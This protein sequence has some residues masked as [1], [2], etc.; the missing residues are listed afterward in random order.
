MKLLVIGSCTGDKD[1]RDCPYTLTAEDF[2]DPRLLRRRESDLEQWMMPASTLYKG[3]QHRYMMRGIDALRQHYGASSCSVKIISAGYGLVGEQQRLA[4]YEVTFQGNRPRAVH[5]RADKLGIPK[6]IRKAV[7]GFD[8]VV[9]L[10]G[11]EYLW[12]INLPLPPNEGQRL[13]FLTSE[14][15]AKIDSRATVVPA[16]RSETRFGAGTVALKGR[17]FQLFAK[18]LCA[19][20]KMWPKL[21]ADKTPTT[22]LNLIE[23]GQKGV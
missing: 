9:F 16:G 21:V 22:F 3:W 19:F 4:P 23:A 13:I 20:P 8:V 2:E 6:E 15:K 17:M 18:G 12:S 5:D 14:P 1:V 11:K 7:A 10:L